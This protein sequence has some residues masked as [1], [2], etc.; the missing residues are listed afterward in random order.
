GMAPDRW[1]QMLVQRGSRNGQVAV[2][3]APSR[4]RAPVT[5]A[6]VPRSSTA[7]SATPHKRF[8]A[9]VQTLLRSRAPLYSIPFLQA[10][11]ASVILPG[12]PGQVVPLRLRALKVPSI[13][14]VS[15]TAVYWM[16]WRVR[17]RAIAA[18]PLSL[19]VI[20]GGAPSQSQ[21]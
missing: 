15:T 4:A 18:A 17:R 1:P 3:L 10:L 11:F 21:Q 19:D 9:L 20:A 2:A 16:A 13:L 8:Q 12:P 14:V 7:A 6:P 5:Q